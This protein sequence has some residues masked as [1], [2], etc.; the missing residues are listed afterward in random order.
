MNQQQVENDAIWAK[1]Y[2]LFVAPSK[3]ITDHTSKRNETL[4]NMLAEYTQRPK[5]MCAEFVRTLCHKDVYAIYKI[6][7]GNTDMDNF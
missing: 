6:F 7:L 4:V 5:A 1:I 3:V 2:P